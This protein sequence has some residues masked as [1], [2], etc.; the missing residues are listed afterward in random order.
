MRGN[1]HDAQ[2][3]SGF[4][5]KIR[6]ESVMEQKGFRFFFKFK[7]QASVPYLVKSV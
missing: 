7:E 4:L 6:S 2:G 5:D 1:H 3:M